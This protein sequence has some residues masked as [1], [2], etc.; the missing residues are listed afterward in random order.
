MIWFASRLERRIR[1]DEGALDRLTQEGLTVEHRD[2]DTD[3]GVHIR[4]LRQ[5]YLLGILEKRPQSL[6]V[7]LDVM[8]EVHLEA[9]D[10]GEKGCLTGETLAA[11]ARETVQRVRPNRQQHP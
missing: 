3:T 5:A 8:G 6:R 2:D 10:T 7:C 9:G 4:I 11:E 1:L